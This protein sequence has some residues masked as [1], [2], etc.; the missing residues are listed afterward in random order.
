M[1]SHVAARPIVLAIGLVAIIIASMAV[2]SAQKAQRQTASVTLERAVSLALD[3]HP[4]V[5]KAELNR[6][7][8]EL[9]LDA[10]R[11]ERSRPSL[12]LSATPFSPALA[13]FPGTSRVD[14]SAQWAL[15][16][17]V[18]LSLSVGATY[19]WDAQ[20]VDWPWNV[21]LSYTWNPSDPSVTDALPEARALERAQRSLRQARDEAVLATIER[22][23]EIRA[24]RSARERAR[25]SLEDARA[26]LAQAKADVEAGRASERD[27]LTA[28]RSLKEAQIQLQ[29]VQNAY[30]NA[31]RALRAD[32]RI[33]RP[34]ELVNP[35]IELN[36]V[37][38][39]AEDL[40]ARAIPDE[41]VA[42]ASS[43]EEARRRVA[44][45]ETE[46]RS[47]ARSR[48]PS[49]TLSPSWQRDQGFQ[50][51]LNL[52]ADLFSPG[53]SPKRERARKALALARH[54]L[55]QAR[56]SAK[57]QIR[58]RQRSLRQALRDVELRR[59]QAEQAQLSTDIARRKRDSG[60]IGPTEWA[61]AQAE[62]RR[63]Q[64]KL[65]RA[66]VELISAYLRYRLAL[67]LDLNWEAMLP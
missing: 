35:Q 31:K 65:A 40:L 60:L 13:E 54:R 23:Q 34:F 6:E 28:K 11:A 53:L 16:V 20:R 17:G 4:S 49:V 48:W 41:A 36:D 14:V 30:N 10:A 2:A 45:A 61:E 58:D 32:L 62:R 3:R 44:K 1:Q 25:A 18:E 57:A 12:G 21:G 55:E 66:E 51:A 33:D 56:R 64:D 42:E 38:S 15:P 26:A 67:G 59:L 8:A 19:D 9:K 43:V 46:L 52:Q 29:Q 27:R 22:F 50:V 24:D 39:R 5:R 47:L 37:I 7:M 63:A